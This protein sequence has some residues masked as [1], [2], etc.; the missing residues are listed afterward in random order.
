MLL[1]DTVPGP[2]VSNSVSTKIRYPTA[3]HARHAVPGPVPSIHICIF[4]NNIIFS[5]E[6]F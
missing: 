3:R 5:M 6:E 1:K 4:I 2:H